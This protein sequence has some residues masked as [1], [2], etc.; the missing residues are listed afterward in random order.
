MEKYRKCGKPG[1]KCTHG[2]LHGPVL[3]ISRRVEGKTRYDYVPKDRGD[4]AKVLVGRHTK[5]YRAR[6]QIQKINQELTQ[7]PHSRD[8]RPLQRG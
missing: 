5:L 6:A 7:L 1:C 2:E 8:K 3:Y 4:L